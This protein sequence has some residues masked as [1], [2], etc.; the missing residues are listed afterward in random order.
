MCVRNLVQGVRLT[1]EHGV[2]RQAVPDVISDAP[3]DDLI[4]VHQQLIQLISKCKALWVNVVNNNNSTRVTLQ[5]SKRVLDE[6]A[7]LKFASSRAASAAE[8]VRLCSRAAVAHFELHASSSRLLRWLLVYNT[9][10]WLDP[11]RRLLASKYVVTAQGDP[12]AVPRYNCL[13][14]VITLYLFIV[15]GALL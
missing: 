3:Q 11:F 4:V 1:R 13:K 8:K 2:R 14:L 10:S 12:D 9:C 7:Y 15:I 5:Q 6:R